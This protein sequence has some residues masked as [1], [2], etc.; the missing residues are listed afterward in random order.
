MVGLAGCA[1]PTPAADGPAPNSMTSLTSG[2]APDPTPAL[3]AHRAGS[4][5]PERPRWLRL[6]N[7]V[8]VP[9]HAVDT[10]SNGILDVPDDIR[11]AG[12]WRGGSRIGDLFGSTLI[13]GHVDSF[14][15]GLGPFAALL[16]ERPGDRL[17]LRSRHLEQVFAVNALRLRPRGTIQRGSWLHSPVGRRRLMLV[18]CASPYIPSKGG[19]QNLAIIVATP[20]GDPHERPSR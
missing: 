10:R 17:V 8:W 4:V 6:A 16:S 14:T 15:Q 1:D 19:Y 20:V 12:W 2:P 11:A 9:V 7:G 5:S 13:A 3:R 18:T